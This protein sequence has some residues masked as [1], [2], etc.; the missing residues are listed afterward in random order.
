MVGLKL[1]ELFVR[2]ISAFMVFVRQELCV[3]VSV[4]IFFDY[5]GF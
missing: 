2:F 5:G 1:L 4:A 3:N